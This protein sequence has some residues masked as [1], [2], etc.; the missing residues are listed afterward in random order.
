[1]NNKITINS[2]MTEIFTPEFFEKQRKEL[3]LKKPKHMIVR[4]DGK[5]CGFVYEDN[6]IKFNGKEYSSK[7]YEE[8][9]KKINE[10]PRYKLI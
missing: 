10:H 1:M 4:S 6:T 2:H 7:K 9:I 3:G 5:V 8:N